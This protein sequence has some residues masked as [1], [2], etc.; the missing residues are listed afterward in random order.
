MKR[1]YGILSVILILATVFGAV[2]SMGDED[3]TPQVT[4]TAT[5]TDVPQTDE[6]KKELAS[7]D[8]VKSAVLYD[9]ESMTRIYSKAGNDE[10]YPAVTGKMMVALVVIEA[11]S[12]ELD[13]T[14]SVP[15]SI[16][17]IQKGAHMELVGKEV[18]SVYDLLAGLIMNNS[19]DAAYTLALHVAGSESEFVKRMNER[20]K[21]LG[22]NNTRYV[23][24]TDAD[25]TGAYTTAEDVV[26]LARVL[27]ENRIYKEISSK[28]VYTIP[29]TNKKGER[30]LYTR[31]YLLSKQIYPNYY[32]SQATGL[33][34]GS[35]IMGGYCAVST[36]RLE[37]REYL[38]VVMT[39]QGSIAEGF[40][41]LIAAKEL[42]LWGSDKYAY[43][44]L[45][46]SSKIMGEIKV[47]LSE[48]YDWVGVIP[49]GEIKHFMLKSLKTEDVVKYESQIFYDVLTAPVKDGEVVGE[50]KVYCEGALVGSL[51]LV[52]RRGLGQSRTESFLKVLGN[53]IT[54]KAMTLGVASVV[55]VLIIGILGKSVWLYRKKIR[56]EIEYEK[57]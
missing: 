45:I 5:V 55:G 21:A 16:A 50:V 7:L 9:V 33:C 42:L 18:I 48:E 47:R 56:I 8:K 23:G 35:S 10:T 53:I 2:V 41:N 51:P 36:A 49:R 43:R 28:T 19:N 26:K 27:I 3:T 40:Y 6:G 13:T 30:K 11:L 17:S 4:P 52:T 15:A 1:I 38:C 54:S 57:Q 34:A 24:V 12:E 39:A 14:V 37:D 20:A 25:E 32:M 29:K 46:D 22:M 31:N 44:T